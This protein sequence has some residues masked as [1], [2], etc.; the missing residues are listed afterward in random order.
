MEC[1]VGDHHQ[2]EQNHVMYRE[3]MELTQDRR[4]V[5]A[6]LCLF[7]E[8]GCCILNELKFVHLMFRSTGKET[9]V[10]V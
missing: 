3:P 6:F 1:F 9:V 7:Y 5:V 10:V 4:D 8:L 2:L